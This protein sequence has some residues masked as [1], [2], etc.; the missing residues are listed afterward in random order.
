MI[1]HGIR[2][3][4]TFKVGCKITP[5]CGHKNEKFKRNMTIELTAKT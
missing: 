2:D 4:F 5:G 3:R 1:N